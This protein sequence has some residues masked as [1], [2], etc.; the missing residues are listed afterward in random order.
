MNEGKEKKMEK[1]TYGAAT[2]LLAEF[3]C[4]SEGIPLIGHKVNIKEI[5][6]ERKKRVIH[7]KDLKLAKNHWLLDTVAIDGEWYWVQND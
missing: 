4:T 6:A 2:E 7:K 5:R 1:D 3:F